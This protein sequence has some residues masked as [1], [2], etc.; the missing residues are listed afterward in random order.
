M[1]RYFVYNNYSIV[2][3]SYTSLL[4]LNI[5]NTWLLQYKIGKQIS[6]HRRTTSSPG[7]DS[8]VHKN[9]ERLIFYKFSHWTAR[10]V[11][12][13]ILSWRRIEHVIKIA[14]DKKEKESFIPYRQ[15]Y[16][17][18]WSGVTM[19]RVISNNV[20][21]LAVPVYSELSSAIVD[22]YFHSWSIVQ[23]TG[24]NHISSHRILWRWNA[25]GLIISCNA[26][27]DIPVDAIL[28]VCLLFSRQYGLSKTLTQHVLRLSEPFCP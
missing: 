13:S 27:D 16:G 14:E 10:M 1:Y 26:T 11:A 8:V 6:K 12:F 2:P 23:N 24:S 5:C 3:Q 20:V 4:S 21:D 17:Y 19:H 28:V 18:W 15:Y 25:S 9:R 7:Q 22:I